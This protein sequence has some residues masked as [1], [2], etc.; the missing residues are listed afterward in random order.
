MVA[1]EVAVNIHTSYSL[2]FNGLV[3][4]IMQLW[5]K[6]LCIKTTVL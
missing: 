1:Q 5:V 6:D 3:R 2:S 4:E